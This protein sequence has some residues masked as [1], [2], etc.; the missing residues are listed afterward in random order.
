MDS[1]KSEAKAPSGYELRPDLRWFAE[2]MEGVLRE[3]DHKHRIGINK[4]FLNMVRETYE[5]NLALSKVNQLNPEI[6]PDLFRKQAIKEA[7]DVA[8]YVMM[9]ANSL[10]GT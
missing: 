4:L 1:G 10:R 3:N 7:T 8:N 2:E 5:L 6:T 9:I